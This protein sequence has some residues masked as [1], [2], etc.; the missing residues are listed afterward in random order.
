MNTGQRFA[1][2]RADLGLN[3]S[4]MAEKTG[5][6]RDSWRRYESGDLP[7]G[8]TLERIA[9]MGY[10]VDWLLTGNG[11]MR[12]NGETMPNTPLGPGANELMKIPEFPIPFDIEQALKSVEGLLRSG[13]RS[14]VVAVVNAKH[15]IELIEHKIYKN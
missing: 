7:T 2:I 1:A 11:R 14:Y 8:E 3:Q 9:A 12:D 5:V 10:S 4:D 6:K 13:P 15:L